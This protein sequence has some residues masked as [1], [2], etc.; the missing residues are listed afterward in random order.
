M[1]QSSYLS[2]TLWQYRG[3]GQFTDVTLA[4]ADGGLPAHSALLAGFMNSFGIRITSMEEMPEVVIIPDLCKREAEDGLKVLYTQPTSTLLVEALKRKTYSDVK[5]EI[6]EDQADIKVDIP[7]EKEN[8]LDPD[9]DDN[10]D[11]RD[12]SYSDGDNDQGEKYVKLEEHNLKP[13]QK[14]F[15]KPD[16]GELDE[17]SEQKPS[18][19]A[20]LYGFRTVKDPKNLKLQKLK[21]GKKP[22]G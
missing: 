17:A 11:E 15:A 14:L 3:S 1:N 2:Q 4:C 8:I 12:A 16:G 10:M 6:I 5:L 22:V 20:E 7:E 19:H 21:T 9:H 18:R 13:T